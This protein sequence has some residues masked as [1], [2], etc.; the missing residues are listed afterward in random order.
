MEHPVR[1]RFLTIS[2]QRGPTQIGLLASLLEKLG[3]PIYPW[4]I[5]CT[6]HAKK[7]GTEKA[8]PSIDTIFSTSIIACQGLKELVICK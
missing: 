1:S 5:S 8:T 2:S 4:L 6:G 3:H 7:Q